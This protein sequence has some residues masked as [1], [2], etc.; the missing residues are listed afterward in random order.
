MPKVADNSPHEPTLKRLTEVDSR[1]PVFCGFVRSIGETLDVRRVPTPDDNDL[2]E[3]A[4]AE[5][6]GVAP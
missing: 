6:P 3:V 1:P 2:E 4:E 5:G